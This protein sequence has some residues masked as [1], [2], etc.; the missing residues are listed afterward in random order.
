MSLKGMPTTSLAPSLRYS[1][2]GL[3][4]AAGVTALYTVPSLGGVGGGAC[5]RGVPR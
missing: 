4:S 2:S 5:E 3:L 1:A